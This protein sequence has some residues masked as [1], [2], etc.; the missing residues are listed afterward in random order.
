MEKILPQTFEHIDENHHLFCTGLKAFLE[1]RK[2]D[3]RNYR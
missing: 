3:G 2:I 1:I